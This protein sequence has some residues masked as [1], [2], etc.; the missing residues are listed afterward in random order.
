MSLKHIR[1]ATPEEIEKIRKGAD[2]GPTSAVMAFDQR[3]GETHLAVVRTVVE[4]DPVF[5]VEGSSTAQKARFIWGLEERLIGANVGHYYFNVP[6][7]D[8]AYARIVT[9]WG[10]KQQSKGP[11]LR[12]GR[13]LVNVNAKD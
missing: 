8:E 13:S 3:E 6:A 5:Y 7:E 12:F 1:V 4:V 11:E 10:A 9:E 2:L